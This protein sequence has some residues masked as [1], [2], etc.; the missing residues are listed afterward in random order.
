[1]TAA[2]E[3]QPAGFPWEAAMAFGLGRL[4]LPPQVFWSMTPRELAAAWRAF[5]P[6][7]AGAPD[8]AALDALMMLFPD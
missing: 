4:A 3:A 2:R 8:R 7:R 6:Q 1:M 5:A